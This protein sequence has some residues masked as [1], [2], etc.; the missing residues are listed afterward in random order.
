MYPSRRYLDSAT[1][2][3]QLLECGGGDMLRSSRVANV[4]VVASP[5]AHGGVGGPPVRTAADVA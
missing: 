4:A 2:T 3:V 1:R 5:K